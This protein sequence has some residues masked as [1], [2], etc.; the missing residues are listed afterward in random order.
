VKDWQPTPILG[1]IPV[2]GRLSCY[3]DGHLLP[4]LCCEGK[5][6]VSICAWSEVRQAFRRTLVASRRR[7]RITA[8]GSR[9]PQRA[10]PHCGAVAPR[11]QGLIVWMVWRGS[12]R[13]RDGLRKATLFDKT[14][15]VLYNSLA[16][17]KTNIAIPTTK[18]SKK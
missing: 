8:Q 1:A 2:H 3:Q 5:Q 12:I 9:N 11:E 18:K 16:D 13:L 7:V 4:V 14:L 10:P 15:A 17:D 6:Q